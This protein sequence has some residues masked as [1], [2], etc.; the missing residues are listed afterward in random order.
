MKA[1]AKDTKVAP[2]ASAERGADVDR[3]VP[4]HPHRHHHQEHLPTHL[5]HRARLR[6]LVLPL[7]QPLHHHGRQ[8]QLARHRKRT[9]QLLELER[10]RPLVNIPI[11][12]RIRI[13]DPV[14]LRH[15][16]QDISLVDIQDDAKIDPDR[17]HTTLPPNLLSRV[18]LLDLRSPLHPLNHQNM[19]EEKPN[20]QRLRIQRRFVDVSVMITI[21]N[22]KL[23]RID[24]DQGRFSSPL[25][26]VEFMD[27]QAQVPRNRSLHIEATAAV[28]GQDST[29]SRQ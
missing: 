3:Q 7:S 27:R 11:E 14:S 1:T 16:N 18:L 5:V 23:R 10:D 2:P 15:L 26:E 29:S 21:P 28:N 8:H 6:P 12:I 24:N 9:L 22:P 4:H 19:I 25:D 20:D 17:L 13:R